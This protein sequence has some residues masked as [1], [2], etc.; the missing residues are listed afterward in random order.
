MTRGSALPVDWAPSLSDYEYAAAR[1]G[2]TIQ[3]TDSLAEDMKLWAGANENRAIAR[4]SDWHKCFKLWCKREA[5]KI[6]RAR[7]FAK[8]Q[9]SKCATVQIV[10]DTDEW[11]A[12]FEYHESIGASYRLTCM[13]TAKADKVAYAVPSQWPPEP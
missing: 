9:A 8:T 11:R 10:P 13:L 1:F 7:Q 6:I 4:K 2:L 3:E 5:W 12:W